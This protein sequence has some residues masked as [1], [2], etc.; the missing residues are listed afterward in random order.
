MPG[1]AAQVRKQPIDKMVS[2]EV[3]AKITAS[4]SLLFCFPLISMGRGRVFRAASS[5]RGQ[6]GWGWENWRRCGKAGAAGWVV[7]AAKRSARHRLEEEEKKSVVLLLRL[8]R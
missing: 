5:V 7:S 2:I 3:T 8:V 6:L 4:A 1:G